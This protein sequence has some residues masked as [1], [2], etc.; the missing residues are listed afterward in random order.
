[1]NELTKPPIDV[2]VGP[3]FHADQ[4]I[5]PRI[6][7]STLRKSIAETALNEPIQEPFTGHDI[8][9][10]G[11]AYETDLPEGV[12]PFSE[13]GHIDPKKMDELAAGNFTLISKGGESDLYDS[14]PDRK[15]SVRKTDAGKVI[16]NGAFQYYWEIGPGKTGR[17]MESLGF[18]VND[19]TENDFVTGVPTPE[20][21]VKVSAQH[22]VAIE[23][24]RGDEHYVDGPTY[25]GAFKAGKYPVSLGTES[26]YRHDTED[27]H[28]TAMVL[29]KEPLR[30]ALAEA[31]DKALGSG[32]RKRIDMAAQDIDTFTAT[33]RSI[34]SPGILLGEAYG[35]QSG[36]RTLLQYGERLGISEDTVSTILST[37]QATARELG[38]EVKELD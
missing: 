38:I 35:R 32:D 16:G 31:A 10:G 17:L 2:S 24:I 6:P 20:T 26:A 23:L 37:A 33:L 18:E 12:N 25:L 4:R 22:G 8:M 19:S 29:G 14:G 15:I 1:M 30:D 13:D 36:R 34:V 21:L 27:D 3:D 7:G 5:H 9:V 28:I 11:E